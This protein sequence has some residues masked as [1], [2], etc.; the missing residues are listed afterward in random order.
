MLKISLKQGQYVNIGD[1]I[2]VVYVG[3][4]GNHGRL[5]IDAPKDVR[6]ARSTVEQNP[7]RRKD[8]YYP[9]PAISKEAQ[10]E[11]KKI[12]WNERMKAETKKDAE[13]MTNAESTAE[14]DAWDKFSK[15][16]EK[17]GIDFNNFDSEEEA[18]NLAK[19]I[20]EKR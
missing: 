19:K 16:L 13:R 10:D 15:D 8:T 6:I 9:E 3:G 14:K 1:N 2:R 5:M 12:L 17:D 7:E 20:Y 11:I 18:L 4:T